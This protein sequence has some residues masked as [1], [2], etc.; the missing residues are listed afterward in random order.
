MW[1]LLKLGLSGAML[2]LS[3]VLLRPIDWAAMLVTLV[4]CLK[5]IGVILLM[6]R[7]RA[8]KSV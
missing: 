7:G 6:G 5:V 1:E 2:A 4:V 8:K 3:P